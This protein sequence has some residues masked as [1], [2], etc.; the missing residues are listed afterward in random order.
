[1]GKNK[2]IRKQIEGHERVI[3]QHRSWIAA[4]RKHPQDKPV[5]RLTIEKWLS[6]ITK[7]ETLIAELERKLPQNRRKR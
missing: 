6:D 7:H 2:D 1:M 5:G 4:G 3:A